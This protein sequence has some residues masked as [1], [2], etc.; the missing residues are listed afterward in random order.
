MRTMVGIRLQGPGNGAGGRRG[1]LACLLVALAAWL[2]GLPAGAAPVVPLPSAARTADEDSALL[3]QLRR[4]EQSG[5]ARPH[6]GAAEIERLLAAADPAPAT[7]VEGLTIQGLLLAAAPDAEAAEAVARRLDAPAPSAAALVR[8]KAA[9]PA[10][11][12]KRAVKLIDEAAARQPTDASALARLRLAFAQAHIRNSASQLDEAIR[13]GHAAL[14]LADDAGVA[15]WQAEARNELAWSYYQARQLDHAKALSDEAMAIARREGDDLTLAHAYTVRGIV[16][17][18][19]GHT[20]IERESLQAALDHARRAGAKYEEALYLANLADYYLKRADYPTALRFAS[21][22]LPLTRELRNLNGETVALANIGLAQIG[23]RDLAAGKNMLQAAIEIDERRG[24][25]TGMSDTYAEMGAALEKAGD[26]AGAIEALHQH[27]LLADQILQRDQQQAILEQRERFDAERRARE[28]DLLRRDGTLQEEQLRTDRLEAA[29]GWLLVA[30]GVLAAAV[31]AMLVRRARQANARLVASNVELQE[32]AE[33]DPLTGLANRRHF[34]AVMQRLGAAEAFAGG[35]LLADLDHFKRINDR[36]GHAAG[37]AVLVEVACRLRQVLRED[38]LVVR[39]GGEEFLVVLRSAAADG[40][41][42]LAQRMLDA[43]GGEPVVFGDG[44]VPVTVSIGYAGFPLPPSNLALP[45][46]RAI[47]LVDT[48]M[49][50]AKAHGRNRAYG[51]KAMHARD[52]AH[53]QAIGRA[54]EDAW[55]A[56]EV[57]LVRLDGPAAVAPGA[58]PRLGVA[59]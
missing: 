24:S 20:E 42:T 31:V 5:R 43:V 11:D 56:G 29:L 37:D 38:D 14:R 4:I 28:L 30:G 54:L 16:Q 23:L 13:H 17:D 26:A 55:H 6:A 58:A 48:A 52:A 27:R 12:P 44:R 7:R 45:W 21:L 32:Q 19:H 8:A 18:A 59:A 49:Y 47:D 57:E 41:P 39:W 33:I 40:V 22:A 46:E 50:L 9:E 36:Y 25:L 35:V 3:R 15:W 1:A 53:A 51:V 2:A 10:G 34:Q